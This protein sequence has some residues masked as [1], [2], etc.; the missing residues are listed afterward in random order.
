VLSRSGAGAR[1]QA[2]EFPVYCP[3]D[4]L[5]VSHGEAGRTFM[6]KKEMLKA[7][8]RRKGGTGRP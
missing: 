3:A 1:A 8:A 6:S 4:S 7:L 5:Y 2:V